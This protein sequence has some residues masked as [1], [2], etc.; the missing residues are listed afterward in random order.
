[1]EILE[2][3]NNI[4][5]KL[6]NIDL[7][8]SKIQENFFES[9]I[10]QIA[11]SALDVGLKRILPDF[12][13]DE[14]I[15]IKDTLLSEGLT[16]GVNKAID[17]AIDLGKTAMGIFTGEF[18][19]IEQAKDA[20][21]K[22]GMLEGIS[23]GLD[24]VLEKLEK[25]NIISSNISTLIKSGKELIINNIDS[26]VDIEFNNEIESLN[27]INNY[28]EK[29]EK[30]YSDKDIEELNKQYKNIQKEMKKIMPLE[31]ILNNVKKIENI[32]EL[33]NNSKNFNFDSVYLDLAKNI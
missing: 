18:E 9:K 31:K 13:E 1:M 33:I 24:Y 12:L 5:D 16:E 20:L 14:V 25:S 8:F 23:D 22:G 21:E 10:G 19:S 7:N 27:K 28:I 4:G 6:K 2:N 26:N 29:W 11:N 32:N 17:S 30:S 3:I 15:E